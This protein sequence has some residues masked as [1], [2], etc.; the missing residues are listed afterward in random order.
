MGTPVPDRRPSANA[1]A[2]TCPSLAAIGWYL[3]PAD[4]HWHSACEAH[5]QVIP[6]WQ[7]GDWRHKVK[8]VR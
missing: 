6:A 3:D 5:A 7:K 8:L 2:R 4:G 1:C